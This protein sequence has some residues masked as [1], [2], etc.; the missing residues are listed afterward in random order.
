MEGEA[1]EGVS[2]HRDVRQTF[3]P[4]YVNGSGVHLLDKGTIGV[5]CCK[6]PSECRHVIPIQ[7]LTFTPL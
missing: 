7:S 1:Q 4:L 5:N 3:G 2:F 6:C